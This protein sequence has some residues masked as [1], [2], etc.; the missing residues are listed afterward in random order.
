[1]FTSE[2]LADDTGKNVAHTEM[3]EK[4]A[5]LAG[6]NNLVGSA[7]EFGLLFAFLANKPGAGK[8]DGEPAISVADVNAMFVE[9]RLPDGWETWKKRGLDWVSSTL[10]LIISAHKE[11]RRLK[12]E[13]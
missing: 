3:Y 9:K 4:L 6:E 8:V 10:E 2:R 13:H 12:N 5:K 1:M 7:G 11:Y